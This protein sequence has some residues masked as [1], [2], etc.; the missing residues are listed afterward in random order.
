MQL[1]AIS[2]MTESFTI[3]C[4][5]SDFSINRHLES[6]KISIPAQC[7]PITCCC[8]SEQIGN[9][10][11]SRLLHEVYTERSEC[12]R[13]DKLLWY[14]IENH[15]TYASANAQSILKLSY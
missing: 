1:I 8:D 15:K 10:D 13:N 3:A 2:G 7:L 14:I 4:H 11:F 9:G 12:A 6:I 5:K